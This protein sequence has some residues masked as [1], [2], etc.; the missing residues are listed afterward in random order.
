MLRREDQRLITGNG[1]FLDDI[2][3]ENMAYLAVA[4][5]PYAHARILSVDHDT[6]ADVEGV[7]TVLTGV[8]YQNRGLGGFGCIY[9]GKR[10]NGED[11][12]VP[13][14]PAVNHEFVKHVGDAVAVVVAETQNAAREAA[15]LIEVDYEPLDVS[16]DTAGA[17]DAGAAV[18][19]PDCPD[20]IGLYAAFGD[21]AA[22][23][24][25]L[26]SA[27]H[28]IEQQFTVT[29]ATANPIEPR[30]AIAVFDGATKRYTLYSGVQAPLGIRN[31]LMAGIFGMPP[32]QLRLIVPDTGGGFGM[33]GGSF[34][35]YA[36]VLWAAEVTGRPIKW[37]ATRS[38]S[39]LSDEQGRDAV[40]DAAMALDKDGRFL[41]LKVSSIAN[42]GAYMSTRGPVTPAGNLGSLAGVY[43]IP[44]MFAEVRAVFTNTPSTAP[45]RGAG[46]PEAAYVIERMVDKAAVLL[47]MDPAELRQMNT[48]P[49]SALPYK[50]ALTFTYDSGAFAENLDKAMVLADYA[51]FA[52]RRAEA[53]ARGKLAGI[54]LSNT[55]ERAAGPTA[56]PDKAK[57]IVEEN[58]AIELTLGSLSQ[59]QGHETTFVDLLVKGLDVETAD[60]TVTTGDSDH[61]LYGVGTFGSR[62]ATMAGAAMTFAIGDLIAHGS[63]RAAEALAVDLA[64]VTYS[65]GLFRAANSNKSI[66]LA[67]I[68]A[69]GEFEDDVTGKTRPGLMGLGEHTAVAPNFPNGAHICEVEVDPETG[70]V[71]LTRYSLVDD[72][73]TVLN[74]IL[75]EGQTHGGIAQGIGQILFEEIVFDAQD[76]QLLT[77]SFMD[78][79]MPRADDLVSI[80]AE[81]NVVPTKTNPLGTKGAGEA[82]VV[83]SFP[84]L[85]NAVEHALRPHGVEHI[86]MPCTPANIWA[87]LKAA[88]QD[89]IV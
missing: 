53:E 57:I 16:V 68:A 58:G 55:I 82:G 87:A 81:F 64:E 35:E 44:A 25:V 67:E 10:M 48:I 69:N 32:E 66:S 84:A 60:I 34:P 17:V 11:K 50:T 78:Y 1:R 37:V 61:T 3:L 33:K 27:D 24:A 54:G 52:E 51:G 89:G 18:I 31:D 47:D 49:P 79:G 22:T 65:A 6:A 20:N 45:Y 70:Q 19:W 30:G 63:K 85:M 77:G 28:V 12:Y 21:A 88:G 14:H 15:E 23:D 86:E 26:K 72:F 73:G 62:T 41:G 9:P 29:R 71:T 38:E 7:I 75:V 74:H 40:F 36:L 42:L 59:G 2:K 80:E 43:D 83:G 76:G 39:F 5:S 46:R 8:D 13:P 4:R 56:V